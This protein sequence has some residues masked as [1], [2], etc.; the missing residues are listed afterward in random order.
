MQDKLI[1]GTSISFGDSDDAF[2]LIRG[3]IE[4]TGG[5]SLSQV[6]TITGLQSSTIQNWVKRSYVPHPENKKYYERHMSR[7]LLINS[8]RES[9][10]IEDV[11]ELMALINGD[12]DD[13]SDDII[14]ESKLYDYF[15]KAIKNVDVER[16]NEKEIE[17]II[18]QIIKDEDSA[19]SERLNDALKVMVS[20]YYG[21]LI[22]K[23]VN[24]YFAKLKGGL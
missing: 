4:I 11:G 22:N 12:T 17:E 15:C 23:K 7:I 24:H 13:E 9:M 10:N 18:D 16:L 5:L 3:M 19:Y 21:S 14:S 1:P 6:C 2:S 8:L 20:T